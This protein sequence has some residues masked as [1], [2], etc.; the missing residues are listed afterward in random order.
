MRL[1]LQV[2]GHYKLDSPGRPFPDPRCLRAAKHTWG[3][4]YV[5]CNI[6]P[7]SR[8]LAA[9]LSLPLSLSLSLS[10]LSL[11]V[12]LSLS[13]PLLAEPNDEQLEMES[14][15]ASQ[16]SRS[17]AQGVLLQALEEMRAV[18]QAGLERARGPDSSIG[19]LGLRGHRARGRPVRILIA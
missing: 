7:P 19:C 17:A 15:P 18:A 16:A 3:A 5:T 9:A 2:L 13:L 1:V 11:S 4:A 8:R 12:S 6:P 10:P 14:C